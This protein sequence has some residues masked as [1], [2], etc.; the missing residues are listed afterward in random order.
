LFYLQYYKIL[1]ESLLFLKPKYI[2]SIH[3]FLPYHKDEPLRNYEIG[4]IFRNKGILVDKLS[5]AFTASGITCRLNE[6]Y[7]MSGGQ[8]HAQDSMMNWNHPDRPE[9]V[10]MNFRSDLCTKRKWR[11]EISDIIKPVITE[12]SSHSK[13]E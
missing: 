13:T 3:T 6:P 9:V 4:L 12:L 2:I 5:N 10:I 8:C 7:D 1:R 11:K